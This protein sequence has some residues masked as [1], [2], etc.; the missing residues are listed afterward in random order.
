MK[1]KKYRIKIACFIILFFSLL[2]LSVK[3]VDIVA[4][5]VYGQKNSIS[6]VT[7]NNTVNVNS[8]TSID[9][10]V[11]DNC[12]ANAVQAV[13]SFPADKIEILSV[14]HENSIIDFWLQEPIYDN[15]NGS[16]ELAGLIL[17]DDCVGETQLAT[18]KV[19][20]KEVGLVN[21]DLLKASLLS[22]D[23]QATE[24]IEELNNLSLMIVDQANLPSLDLN[25]DEV[26]SIKDLS[27]FIANFKDSYQTIYDL[28]QDGKI[29]M[30]D[31]S[32]LVYH[33]VIE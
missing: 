32:I 4:Q 30:I 1:R 15:Q 2:Y 31:L 9:F 29:N 13:V 20:A 33:A 23:G 26:I 3:A 8:T 24:I 27:I 18:V 22:N 21:L 14:N 28:N 17:N 25:N 6:I 7:N 16:L 12:L 19:L 11:N 10:L 5:Q